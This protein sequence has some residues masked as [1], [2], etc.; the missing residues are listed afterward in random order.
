[1][2]RFKAKYRYSVILLKQLVI[3]DFKLRYQN[4]ILGYLWTLLRPMGLFL[5]LYIVFVKFLR[6]GDTIPHFA[7]YLLLGIVFWNFFVEVTLGSLGSIVG[8]SD[9]IRKINFPKYI[10]VVSGSISALINLF[11]NGIVVTVFMIISHASVRI[12]AIGFLPLLF[13]ELYLFSLAIG[14]LLSA[15]YVRYRDVNY[16]WEVSMQGLFYATPLLYPVSKITDRS[17]IAAKIIMLNPLAQMVQDIRYITI[18]TVS[19]TIGTIYHS[20][21]ARFVPIVFTILIFLV[22]VRYFRKRSPYFAEEV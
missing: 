21:I 2:Q 5:I 16:I 13:I 3:T 9:L 7:A 4:S 12:S 6:V 8:R 19:P 20:S 14:F 22:A 1:M 17:P 18:T 15:L 10:I 11:L